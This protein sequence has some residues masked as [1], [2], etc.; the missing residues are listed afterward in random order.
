MDVEGDEED[1]LLG[2]TQWGSVEQVVAEVHTTEGRPDRV[3]RL[4]ESHGFL[5]V[6]EQGAAPNSIM[7]YAAKEDRVLNSESAG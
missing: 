7:I 6:A 3:K 4:L 1:V 2:M 5:V